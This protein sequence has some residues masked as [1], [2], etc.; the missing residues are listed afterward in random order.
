MIQWKIELEAEAGAPPPL[1]TGQSSS[2]HHLWAVAWFGA[3]GTLR[4]RVQ[5]FNHRGV[6]TRRLWPA[7]GINF[8]TVESFFLFFFF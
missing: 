1:V 5:S 4:D 2:K 7:L 8:G 3:A 6:L